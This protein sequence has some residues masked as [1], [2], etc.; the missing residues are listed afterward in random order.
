MV[1]KFKVRGAEAVYCLEEE[2]R[3]GWWYNRDSELAVVVCQKGLR[4]IKL[5]T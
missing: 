3:S 1:K 5:P 2:K 4:Q